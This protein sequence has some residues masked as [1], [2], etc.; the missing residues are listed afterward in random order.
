MVVEINRRCELVYDLKDVS[1]IIRKYYNCEL[2][3]EMDRLLEENQDYI[4]GLNEEIK[5]L[6]SR[7]GAI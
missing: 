5:I 1:N 2:A 6:E 7:W 4:D 3:D